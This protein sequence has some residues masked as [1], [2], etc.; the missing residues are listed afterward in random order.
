MYNMHKELFVANR[1]LEDKWKQIKYH[2]EKKRLCTIYNT[3]SFINS[4]SP[5]QLPHLQQR[6]KQAQINEGISIINDRFTEIEKHNS[7]LLKRMT[8]IMHR[9]PYGIRCNSSS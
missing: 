2:D 1:F 5:P 9:K 8:D 7:I 4:G 3:K 6:L